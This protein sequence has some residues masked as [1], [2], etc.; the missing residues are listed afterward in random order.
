MLSGST[1]SSG[2]GAT[3]CVRCRVIDSSRIEAVAD[4]PIQSASSPA[5]GRGASASAAACVSAGPAA[6]A[7]PVARHASHAAPSAATTKAP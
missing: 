5:P 2:I 1:H 6:A 4:R 3:S 7:G